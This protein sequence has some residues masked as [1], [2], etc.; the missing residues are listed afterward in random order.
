[1]IRLFPRTLRLRITLL[2]TIVFGIISGGAGMITYL[3]L[4]KNLY[5]RIDRGLFEKMKQVE[6]LISQS[7]LDIEAWESINSTIHE[8]TESGNFIHFVQIVRTADRGLIVNSR[9]DQRD[10]THRVD[11][12]EENPC[13]IEANN[14]NLRVYRY[15]D[16]DYEIYVASPIDIV[17]HTFNEI[18]V[19]Y[20][21]F[22]PLALLIASISVFI[23]IQRS[24]KPITIATRTAESITST[25]LEERLPP[26][27]LDDEVGEL[28]NT[29]NHM[30]ARLEDAFNQITQFMADAAHELHTPLTILRGELEVALRRHDLEKNSV[31][32]LQSNL[33]EVNRLIN[34]VES[35]FTLARI[36]AKQ[37]PIEFAPVE[38]DVLLHEL[39]NKAFVLAEPKNISVELSKNDAV[40]VNG[41]TYR[42]IQLFL[43]LIN[44]AIRYTPEGGTITLSC[45]KL[46]SRARVRVSDTGIGIPQSE[47]EKIFNRF[48]RVDKARSREMGGSGLGL[49]IAQRVVDLHH[50]S[51]SVQ[52]E[53]GK[54][55][56]FE[57]ILPMNKNV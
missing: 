48:Y 19:T 21:I 7:S 9:K 18:Q 12:S 20:F 40:V 22:L 11:E 37:L 52:S 47:L 30:I 27:V 8:E 2:F 44:N 55:S 43:N 54:G 29:L 6:K 26:P 31:R 1:M 51:I 13:N 25:N 3:H 24:L 56:T 41:D 38:L 15:K 17:V 33:D 57:V 36:D 23:I 50:G 32:L 53:E 45:E 42:L 4:H 34:I 46:Q 35:L 14:L 10:F 49:S 39:Y 5:E 16:H 28:V